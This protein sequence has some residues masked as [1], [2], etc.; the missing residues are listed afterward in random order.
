MKKVLLITLLLLGSV[1]RLNA[2]VGI[3]TPTPHGT[4]DLG[5]NSG[6]DIN[7]VKGKKLAI[8]NTSSGNYFYG[9]GISPNTLQFHASSSPT[10]APAMVLQNTGNL[11]IGTVTPSPSALIEMAST[12]KGLLPPRMSTVQR[13]GITPKP[14]GLVIYNLDIHC[15][16][17]WNATE[18]IGNCSNSNGG[19]VATITNCTTT[20]LS[21][22]YQQGMAMNSSNTVVLAV[23]VTQLGAWSAASNS[24]NGVT[25]SGSGNFTALG[26][27]NITLTATGTASSGGTFNYT[28]TLGNSTC[29]RPITYS[30]G[31]GVATITN[32]TTTT[33]NGTYQQGMAMNSSNTVV[34]TVNVTQ[35]GAW[36]A[37]SNTANGISFSGSGTF[38][39]LGN[40]NITLTATGT[41]SNSGS[42]NYN[43]NL[44]SSNCSGRSINFGTAPLTICDIGPADVPNSFTISG[45]NVSI[46]ATHTGSTNNSQ[47]T[48]CAGGG[49][50][51]DFAT[52]WALGWNGSATAT[53]TT[54]T[55]S[56]PV[57]DVEIFLSE[58]NS[59]QAV[60]F[61]AQNGGGASFSPTLTTTAYCAAGAHSISGNTVSASTSGVR[62]NT[63]L[64]IQA[65]GA[66]FTTLT[67]THNGL[68]NTLGGSVQPSFN[69]TAAQLVIC[70]ATAQ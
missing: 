7:D 47:I 32:C 31:G 65:G 58:L 59:G 29:T 62:R 5:T 26:N 64:K 14:E 43:F 38:T 16:Q 6:I 33:L 8:Y 37:T 44:G 42:F 2:Q 23:N 9:F 41:P 54:F 40:Q 15:L 48:N 55:F 45:L 69:G 52:S 61:T 50:Q 67:I 24:M 57:K 49:A 22:T 35:L 21:G 3:G 68:P 28:Y 46:S 36:S 53:T 63:G 12:S 13:D 30:N 34:L 66:Y 20:A 51:V 4:L 19:G 18:W 25:F 1:I 27:Q 56:R 17:Y 10:G 60:T 11:G 70:N 39:A